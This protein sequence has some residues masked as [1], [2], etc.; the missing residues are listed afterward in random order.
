MQLSPRSPYFIVK[1]ITIVRELVPAHRGFEGGGGRGQQH[2]SFVRTS[3]IIVQGFLD[4][5]DDD[6]TR[7]GSQCPHADTSEEGRTSKRRGTSEAKCMAIE[8]ERDIASMGEC[9][10]H[11]ASWTVLEILNSTR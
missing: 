2:E 9:V 7:E 5:D 1:D 11:I 4:D 8:L 3:A 6:D 10:W